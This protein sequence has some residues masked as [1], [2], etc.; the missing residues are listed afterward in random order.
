MS[1]A[2]KL[3]TLVL[4]L[5]EVYAGWHHAFRTQ[6]T[7][8]TD[9]DFAWLRKGVD[10]LCHTFW[11]VLPT[12]PM[13]GKR[14]VLAGHNILHWPSAAA[15][16][17]VDLLW[18]LTI[19]QKIAL[20]KDIERLRDDESPEAP[21][22]W[23]T[24]FDKEPRMTYPAFT[25]SRDG[26]LLHCWHSV[27]ANVEDDPRGFWWVGADKETI[28]LFVDALVP[29]AYQKLQVRNGATYWLPY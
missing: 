6:N 9:R 4:S 18:M 24:I 8:P 25:L 3:A 2:S 23:V 1:N 28:S 11:G 12:I 22:A 16:M 13:E 19:P 5:R 10:M 20:L 21:D 27:P 14:E 17:F 7:L 15:E 29:N 26:T